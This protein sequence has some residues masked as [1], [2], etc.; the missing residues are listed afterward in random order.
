VK[1]KVK[2]TSLNS[3]V[4]IHD[5][6]GGHILSPGEEVVVDKEPVNSTVLQIEKIEEIRK[7][8]IKED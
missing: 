4:T 3:W 8:K 7:K 2:N 5:S 6:E 1:W